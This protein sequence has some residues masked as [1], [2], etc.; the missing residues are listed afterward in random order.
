MQATAHQTLAGALDLGHREL[1]AVVGGG[2]KTTALRL[3]AQELAAAGSRVVATTTTAMYLRELAQTGPVVMAANLPELLAG[4]KKALAEGG[5]AGA[6]SAPGDEGKVVGLPVGWVDELWADAP[7]DYLIVE[8]DGS[9]GR[10]LKA[11]GPHEPQVPAAT[12]IVVQVAG[13]DALGASLTEEY[14]HRAGLVAA[15]LDVPLGS[16]ITARLFAGCLREQGR[17]LRQRWPGARV[18]T[19]LNKADGPDER[20][21]GS[22]LA[23]EVLA[24]P[25]GESACR[26]R[27]RGPDSVVVAS[28]RKGLFLRVRRSGE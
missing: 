19:V 1:V 15:A 8:A 6:A 28:L 10:P 13:L 23:G 25:G 24:I 26:T 7:P 5:S 16:V 11:F 4:L 20:V 22:H 12:T 3:L 9:R 27:D 14:V 2:G 21:A 17:V 18:V